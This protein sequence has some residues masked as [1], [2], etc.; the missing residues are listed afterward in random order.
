MKTITRVAEME[1][2]IN[3]YNAGK[4]L[5]I[6][7]FLWEKKKLFFLFILFVFFFSVTKPL[8]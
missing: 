3:L 6:R 4:R 5:S 2:Y 7:L 1:L 8:H